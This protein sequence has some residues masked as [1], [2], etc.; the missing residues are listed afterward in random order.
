MSALWRLLNN[1]LGLAMRHWLPKQALHRLP[2]GNFTHISAQLKKQF[3]MPLEYGNQSPPLPAEQQQ[4]QVLRRNRHRGSGVK[5]PV[6]IIGRI[7]DLDIKGTR[8]IWV[9]HGSAACQTII[10]FLRYKYKADATMT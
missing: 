10:D 2:C 1:A 8:I 4:R 7:K 5:I 3:R 9:Q 6:V